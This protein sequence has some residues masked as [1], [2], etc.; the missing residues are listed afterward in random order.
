MG[1]PILWRRSSPYSTTRLIWGR[2]A[3]GVIFDADSESAVRILNGRTVTEIRSPE[4]LPE[5][6]SR[7]ALLTYPGV[8]LDPDSE[9]VVRIQKYCTFTEIFNFYHKI[10]Y[11]HMPITW[12]T[13]LY[14]HI[15]THTHTYIHIHRTY[16]YT[17]TYRVN[18]GT[19]PIL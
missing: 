12:S 3:P 11:F 1:G 2:K 14:A 19:C 6:F 15:H 17:H 16:A 5:K 7:P 13:H 18:N 10:L 4:I 9:S 8:H